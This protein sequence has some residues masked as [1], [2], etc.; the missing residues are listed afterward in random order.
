MKQE[1]TRMELIKIRL[2]SIAPTCMNVLPKSVQRLL[3]EDIPW[4]FDQLEGKPC[5][6]L[7]S[8]SS[9]ASPF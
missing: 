5:R 7:E 6:R 9:P 4:L 1:P 3:E 8:S 2:E